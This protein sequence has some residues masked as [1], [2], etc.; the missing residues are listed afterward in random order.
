MNKYI[1]VL[2]DMLTQRGYIITEDNYESNNIIGINSLKTKIIVFTTPVVKFNVDTVKEFI[3]ITNNLNIDHCIVI[4]SL[5]VTSMAKKLIENS[6]DVKIELFKL[7]EVQFNITSHILVPLHIK[8]SDVDATKFKD[9]YGVKF[10]TIL[11][12]DPIAR[13]YNYQKGDIIKI[14]RNGNYVTYRICK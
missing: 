6:F 4:Y 2:R 1:D 10:P 13:F 3:T 8:L 14:I 7:D 12:T 9:L 11:K 5:S